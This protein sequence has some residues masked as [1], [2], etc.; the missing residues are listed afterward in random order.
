MTIDELKNAFEKAGYCSNDHITYAVYAAMLCHRP[1][2]IEGDPGVGKTSLA[3]AF[4]KGM[5]LECIRVQM[6]EGLTADQIL[7]DYDYQKQL[8]TLE[9]VRPKLDAEYKDLTMQES[10]QKAVK[11][12]DFYGEDFL[13]KR[14]VLRSLTGEPKV[15]LIDEMDKAPEELEYSLYEILE[16]YSMTIPQYGTIKAE[17]PPYVFITSNNYRDLSGALKRRCNYLYINRKTED[18]MYEII[19]VQAKT[20]DKIAMGIARCMA[21]LQ[22]ISLHQ[23]PSIAE[24]VEFAKYLSMN[25]TVTKTLVMNSLSFLSKHKND[26]AQIRQ[27]VDE[28]GEILWKKS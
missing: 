5:G 8:L 9:A 4:A 17:N 12:M 23:V 20:N 10:I 27:I 18:E 1:L 19:K 22:D 14:P 26:E 11:S 7:Y 21:A 25:K 15:L 2:L 24:A 28:N 6:Y 3:K 16:N 13:I